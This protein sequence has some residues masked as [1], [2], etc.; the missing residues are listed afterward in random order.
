METMPL[1]YVESYLTQITS[2]Q[3]AINKQTDR[4]DE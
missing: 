4:S 2:I 1:K 3:N